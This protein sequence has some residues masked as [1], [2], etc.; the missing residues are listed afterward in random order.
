MRSSPNSN[1]NW[2]SQPLPASTRGRGTTTCIS[3]TEVR[4]AAGHLLRASSAA[5]SGATSSSSVDEQLLGEARARG[6]R[7]RAS[8]DARG[9][10]RS[11]RRA[12]SPRSRVV[13]AQQARRDVRPRLEDPRR[14]AVAEQDLAR[15]EDPRAQHRLPLG[16]SR[17]AG[18]LTAREDL[19]DDHLDEAVEDVAPCWR[20]GCRA[21]SP[22]PR[23]P[24]RGCASSAPRCRARRRSPRPRAAHAPGSAAGVS[25]RLSHVHRKL[26]A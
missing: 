25:A 12:S 23:A 2:S 1:S 10:A 15:G 14:P 8:R 26:E 5:S 24:D 21:T 4:E 18:P 22:R 9:R 13:V 16:R 17:A 19:V 11:R 7:A 20:R 6:C 3:S